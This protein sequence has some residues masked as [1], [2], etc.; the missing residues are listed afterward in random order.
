MILDR[1]RLDGKVADRHRR[2][3]R[4]RRRH[5]AGIRRGGR[6][7][8]SC[9]ARTRERVEGDRRAGARARAARRCR[10]VCDVMERAQLE[11]LV[12]Q[13]MREFGRIDILGQQRRR[14]AAACQALE[15]SERTFEQ[16]LRFNVTTALSCSRRLVRAA[17]ARRRRRQHRQHLVRG[18]APG[19]WPGSSPTAPPRRRSRS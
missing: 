9:A 8:A 16:A 7:R 10:L 17:H 12:A 15:T 2:G 11:E 1:F 19:R 14:L 3:A 6:A 13:T 4:H 5:R 18:R